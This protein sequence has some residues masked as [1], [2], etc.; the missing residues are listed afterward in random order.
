MSRIAVI[1]AGIS[2]LSAAYFLSRKHQVWLF[3]KERRLGG[4]THTHRIETT[5]GTLSVDTGFIVHNDRTY[6]NFLRLMQEL[7]VERERSDMS[8]GVTD[9]A[10]GLE[11]SS[12]GLNGLFAQRA[13]FFRPQH[14]GLLLEI[15]RFNKTAAKFLDDPDNAN[16]TLH[17]YLRMQ[18]FS[19][20]FAQYYLYPMAGAVWSTSLEEIGNFPAF[21]L[22]RFFYNHGFLGYYGQPTWYTLQSGSS[23]YIG[24]IIQPYEGRITTAIQITGVLRTDRSVLVTFADQR[25]QQF[26]EVVFACHAPQALALLK[27]AT[28]LEVDILG[29]FTTT[30]N[31]VALHTDPSLLPRRTAARA[32]WNYLLGEGKTSG[33]TVTYHMNRLQAFNA[34][35]EYCVTLNA[36]EAIDSRRILREMQYNHPLYNLDAIRAQARW[37]EISGQNHTHFCGA[38]WF[39][40]FHEDGINS[41]LRVA[42]A[43]GVDW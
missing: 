40:G 14:Y 30:C 43:L 20:R 26:D 41:A 22:I 2:G 17:E 5:R 3:E 7:G 12:R 25:A 6:P 28:Q 23:Q 9:R 32:S 39:Y 11:Y 33:V 29:K 37:A 10:T 24:P 18:G 31:H 8:F 36:T 16:V 34:D 27:D 4:H 42:K 13:N 15:L 21:T 35:E 1:G 38:Y 19:H